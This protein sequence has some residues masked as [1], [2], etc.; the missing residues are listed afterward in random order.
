MEQRTATFHCKHLTSDAITWRVNRTALNAI[1]SPNISSASF[2][3]ADGGIIYKLIFDTLLEFNQTTV[4]CVAI[5]FNAFQLPEFTVPVILQIQGTS[6][7]S[8]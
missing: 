3:D 2:H 5:F 6:N 4:E 8:D 7:L 1:N